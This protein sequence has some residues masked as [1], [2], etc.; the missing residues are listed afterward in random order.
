M[1]FLR[2]LRTA[3]T[4]IKGCENWP[5]VFL[6]K[7]GLFS[8][9]QEL[10]IRQGPKIEM[11]IPLRQQC[12]QLFEAAVADIYGIRQAP[13]EIIVDVGANIGAFSCL[14]AWTHPHAQVYA[15][16]PNPSAIR[17]AR[18]NFRRNGL[19]NIHLMESPVTGDGREVVIH[20]GDEL[21]SASILD[22]GKRGEGADAKRLS[23]LCPLR[24]GQNHFLQARL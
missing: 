8:N 13:A 6:A 10:Q 17:Q 19:E 2:K 9:V 20:I 3:F 22:N 23:R 24:P 4:T 1:V 11:E 14:A 12:G 5:S 18:V 7:L 21:G 15:F 16:E